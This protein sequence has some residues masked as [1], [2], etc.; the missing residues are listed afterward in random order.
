MEPNDDN[1]KIGI[2]R[3]RS[4]WD[5]FISSSP[6][7]NIFSRTCFL[8]AIQSNYD[9]WIVEKNNKIQAGA[10]ILRNNKKVVK[11][12]YTFSLYQGIYLSS[13]LEQMP[14][15]SRVVFQSRTIKALL[16][17][18]TKKY[19]CVSFCLHHSLIDLREFQWFNYHNPTLGR[20]QFDLRYT[21]LIDLSLVR[22]FD[23]YLMS[24]RKTRRNE[25]RQSQKLFTVKKSKDLKTFDKLHRLTFE[26][27]NIKRTEEEIFLLKSITKN[28]IEKK[29][30][31]LLFCYNKDNK[32]V[33]ATLFI[34]D[35][36][37]GYYLFGANDPDCRKSN[38][39]TFLLLENIRRCKERGVKYVDV[40]GINSPNRGDFKVGLNANPTR[41]YITTWQKPNNNAEYLPYSLDNLS[42]FS[43]WPSIITGNSP[44]IQFHK[45][46]GE[47]EREF[48]KEKWDILLRKVLST[49]KHASL[50]EVENLYFGGQKNLCFNNGKFTLLKLGSAQKKYRLLIS[51]YLKNISGES[52]I[53]ELGSGYGSVIL[54]LAKRKEF[55]KNKFFAADISKNGRELTR[56]IA[57][58]ENLDVTILPCDL[59][60][61]TI[62][63]GI[64]EN[65]ILLTSY[66]V[67]YQP[68][69]SHQFVESL[70]KLKPKAVIHFEPIYEHCETKSLF[71]QLRKRYIEI[72]DYN[73]N[74]MTV[75]KQA[76]N[77]NRIK[78]TKINPVVFG[79]NSLLPVSVIIWQPKKK[80]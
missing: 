10:I 35:K 26:R 74:L 25:Y 54:D 49:N 64:P 6:Q 78:I 69:L 8:N 11:Q 12:Q 28:A 13:Q 58:N 55:R 7:D 66:S 48:D 61:K 23:E 42:Q 24:I 38:S 33:S 72:S 2:T 39:G 60:K 17:R 22:N 67:H 70:I 51:D 73:R 15:H 63:S 59:T 47:I 68:H 21:G 50:R 57:T 37:C 76:E 45:N 3:N 40:C 71:G 14:Q 32:P 44:M 4:K 79:A 5:K 77:K 46:K 80:P 34:Y 75:L 41:Y 36:N 20:F 27:Q 53:V 52:P 62:V 16:D 65:S 56:L 30:G 29:F 18:L 19:D 9:T 1:Y 31:E 43:E